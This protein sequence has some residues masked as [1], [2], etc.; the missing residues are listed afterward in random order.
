MT[1]SAACTR[2][3]RLGLVVLTALLV[4]GILLG[5]LPTQAQSLLS[6]PRGSGGQI[7]LALPTT[8]APDRTG[9]PDGELLTLPEMFLNVAPGEPR[10]PITTLTVL[11]PPDVIPESVRVAIDSP[12]WTPLPEPYEIPAAPP[13]VA[14]NE[15]GTLDWNGHRP[16]AFEQGQLIEIYE[17]DAF[18]PSQPVTLLTVGSQRDWQILTVAY[19]PLAY[20]PVQGIVRQLTGGT[21]RVTF[22][23]SG[24]ASL[25]LDPASDAAWQTLAPLLLNPGDRTHYTERS[26]PEG[27]TPQGA[28]PAAANDYVI[29][30]TNAIVANSTQ[31]S[32]F[33][34]SKQQ[35]GFGV[36]IVTEGA[37][38]TATT[39]AGGG[40]ANQRADNIRQWLASRF[41]TEGIRY[42]LLIG[43]PTPGNLSNTSVPMKV[44]HPHNEPV[45]TDM[46]YSDLA[47]NWD[48][49]GNGR[50]G[51][52]S[53]IGPGGINRLP[54]VYVGRVP[55]Y[56]S[57]QAL[58]SIL[59]KFIAY[60]GATGDI[61]WRSR[62]LI[63]P[64]IMNHGPQDNHNDG[65]ADFKDWQ[66][67]YKAD[68]GEALKAL[69][70][71]RGMGA[72]TLYEKQGVYHDGSAYSLTA[73]NAPL[74]LENF[75]NA[76]KH[77]YGFV[78]WT[79]HGWA[80]GAHRRVW[81]HDNTRRDRITQHGQE[82]ASPAFMTR[83]AAWE[84]NNARPAFVVQ[85]SCLNGY[86]ESGLNLG[87]QLLWNGAVG[88]ISS[89]R[90]SYYT[91]GAWAYQG[92]PGL[93][94]N[95][96]LA[97]QVLDRM[98]RLDETVGEALAYYR[99]HAQHWDI[100]PLWQ[101]ML[102]SN[103][104]GDPSLSL[105]SSTPVC[106]SPPET[107]SA[108]DPT[109]GRLTYLMRPQLE[110]RGGHSCAGEAVSYDVY[111]SANSTT[112]STLVCSNV[113]KTRCDAGPLQPST[114]Y[115]W[116]VVAK[117]EN[118]PVSG[119]VWTFETHS[120][121]FDHHIYVPFSRR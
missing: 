50:F 35:A 17:R 69:A 43:D 10:L 119:P 4:V 80:E 3:R 81:E 60:Q 48:R 75:V 76:W 101:N 31:L 97:Y 45:P 110:W 113:Q 34:Q 67:T 86:P 116:R 57:Y 62:A 87:Y 59:A 95:A 56:G 12:K 103:L 121:H 33:V 84:L 99:A 107:P 36:K 23:R 88:T 49:N 104:Y 13:L 100:K 73:S 26:Q 65:S 9:T 71:S 58:D 82:T 89:S 44:T 96:T 54:D 77:G 24:A 40:S 108:P 6:P 22:E 74:T 11:L 72:Y 90:L 68:W 21:L 83:Q 30:T 115:T 106:T 37:S 27:E 28:V 8:G 51:E 14:S 29:I 61:S 19:W 42:V 55:F 85:V 46:Y 39:Y 32:A 98:T 111:L 53:D 114:Q 117:G 78:A 25:A 120:G 92:D 102:V 16:E 2:M 7:S 41:A 38:A 52:L 20:N 94:D 15:E 91:L 105:A 5:G 112:P 70:Q 66:R 64:A 63:A 93:G 18:W 79:G 47:G 1:P 109:H 118:G